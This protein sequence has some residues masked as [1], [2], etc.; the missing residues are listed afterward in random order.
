M[1]VCGCRASPARCASSAM[2]LMFTTVVHHDVLVAV[3]SMLLNVLNR[4]V[5]YSVIDVESHSIDEE[6]TPVVVQRFTH[7]LMF[8][9]GVVL[10]S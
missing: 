5:M 2:M 10:A 4:M 7:T 8:N 9:R 6:V 3:V 1:C